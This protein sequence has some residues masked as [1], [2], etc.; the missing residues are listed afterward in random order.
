MK[1]V[2]VYYAY[3]NQ[4]SSLDLRGYARAAREMGHEAIVYG[5]PNAKIALNY[6]TDVAGADAVVFVFE[7]TTDLL[8]GD[9]LDWLRLISSVP[10]SRRVVIDCDGRYNDPINV[11]GDYNHRTPAESATY[12]DFCDTLADKVLQPT[13]RPLRPNVGTFLFHIYDPAWETPLD[14]SA[15]DFSIVYVGHSKFRWHGMS[16]VLRAVEPVRDRVG[17]I[18]LFGYGWDK[19]P[20][21]AESM[22]MEDAYQ[23]DYNYMKAQ[24]VEAM[25]PIPTAEVIST[26]SRGSI[27]PVVYRP[28]FEHLEFVTCRTFENLAAGTI[29]LFLL[30]ADYV[31]SVFGDEAAE[32][33]VLGGDRPQDK[34]VDV[35]ERPQH[36]AGIVQR[37]RQEFLVHHT[38]EARLRQL[39]E[40]IRE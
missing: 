23:V 21:W 20:D 29:P 18:A 37:A 6:S 15:K 17:R 2:F 24:R 25:P 12:V 11:H 38:P 28:L 10:R 35:L 14:A 27:N 7:W 8:Y 4:G 31:R 1:I 39:I 33:L 36:Y 40:I 5:V 19:Q 13:P 16:Q 34:I 32:T 30:D 3:E 26:M 9:R 22:Q